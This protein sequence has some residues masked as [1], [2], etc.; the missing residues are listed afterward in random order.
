MTLN[1]IAIDQL[2]HTSPVTIK[3]LKLLDINT[4]WDLLNYFP[5]RYEN[6]SLISQINKLQPEEVVTVKGKINKINNIYTRSGIKIQKAVISDETGSLDLIWYNQPYLLRLLT[7]R[8]F[9]AISGKIERE[10]SHLVMKPQEY[11]LLT[12]LDQ[13]TIHTGR[14]VPIYPEYHGLSSKTIRDKLYYLI[15]GILPLNQRPYRSGNDLEYLPIEIIKFNQLA[16]ELSSYKN[17]HFPRDS[18]LAKKARDRLAFDELFMIQLS[19]QLIKNQ[20][21][22]EIVRKP[23][24]LDNHKQQ[25]IVKFI[26]N[27]PFKLTSSQNTVI[28]EIMI[29]L[30]K[31]TPMNR[32]L[33]GEVGSGKTVVA[34]ISSYF[35][36]LNN[37]QT[38]FMAPT[39]ILTHQHYQTLID[40]FRQTNLKITLI[41]GSIKP[42][43]VEI[44]NADLI[45]G[46]Q[47]LV[48]K[49]IKFNN[50]GLVV[51][52]EQHRF[53]VHQR[54]VLKEKGVNPHLLSMTA[55]PIPRTVALTLYGE[56]DLST[57]DEIPIGRLPIKTF[58]VSKEKRNNC[59]QW[60]KS[61]IT[62]NKSQVF[63]ICPLIE[64]STMETMKSVK[65]VT[66]EYQYLK[67][68]IFPNLNIGLLHGK[69]KP[70]E[71][72][73]IMTDFKNK[74]YDILVST[75]VVEVGI[76][77]S[78]ATIIII[79][80]AERYGLAQL[81]QLR[82]R[83]GR[84][85]KQSYCLLFTES[86]NYQVKKRLD[87]FVKTNDGNYLA[88][89]DLK[90]R[91]PGDVYG[92]RQ[93]GYA[94]LKIASLTDYE[95]IT[96]AKKASGYFIIKYKLD[97]F[98]ELKH[99]LDQYQLQQI[100]RD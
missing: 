99:R 56:L 32:L 22:K 29:D 38:L 55:T 81:H 78:N 3:R 23:L 89:Y 63:I 65:A 6:Y 83:V 62:N 98:T 91:G 25:L 17:I 35:A 28:K 80:G 45:L 85:E 75:S 51:V 64:E 9:V 90:V 50:V 48:Q 31:K 43:T 12:S 42:K 77:I 30:Q 59:Y 21:K 4:Y 67:E 93:H 18:L 68:K 73:Q 92:T 19:T 76:D 74:K 54:A 97:D 49:K 36:K 40:V 16:D 34:A 69:L 79:E 66:K 44:N 53:G 57:I 26:N 24:I 86:E 96:K 71:K 5:Y 61:Q 84:G 13:E 46:T 10:R 72:N 60:I 27:L 82:G 39:E 33:Q 1:N 41:T 88:E 100:S 15:S 52:D 94:N 70:K 8:D 11:E 58:F 87:L 95:L 2:P 47:A 20:W 7:G 14:F 37:Y